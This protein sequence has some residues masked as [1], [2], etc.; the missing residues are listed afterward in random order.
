M[1]TFHK[2]V[3]SF[4]AASVTVLASGQALGQVAAAPPAALNSNAVS[5]DG[6]DSDLQNAGDDKGNR[7]GPGELEQNQGDPPAPPLVTADIAS[8]YIDVRPDTSDPQPVA[9]RVE[10]GDHAGWV[11]LVHVDYDDGPQGLVNV[12]IAR[13]G[14][15]DAEFHTP[16]QWLGSGDK[17]VVT[18]GLVWPNGA[19][20]RVVAVSGSCSAPVE[21]APAC[22]GEGEQTWQLGD[23][24]GDGQVTFFAD[25]FKMFLN[26]AAA[27]SP[28]WTGPDSGY[29]VDMQVG[30]A[31][32]D[33]FLEPDQQVTFFADIFSAFKCTFGAGEGS[34]VCSNTWPCPRICDCP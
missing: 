28:G 21:S 16:A 29:E 1:K 17:L 32:P 33:V 15:D 34:C 25:L 6:A 11:R 20:P 26:S 5:H 10:C 18:G 23:T 2:L 22:P 7:V 14:C 19:R 8:R 24:S 13:E 12:G 27:G 4:L 3:S 30:L 31:S 9:L